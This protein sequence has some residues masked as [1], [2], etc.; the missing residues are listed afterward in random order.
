M[1]TVRR[2]WILSVLAVPLVAGACGAPVAP[3]SNLP[4]VSGNYSQPP[5]PAHAEELTAAPS[6]TP[7]TAS[8]G[9]PLA[10]LRPFPDP[11]SPPPSAALDAIRSHGRL[12]V[13]LD[14]GSNLF[15]FRD[16]VT[17]QIEGFDVDISREI[18]AD[19]LGS[20]DR[21]V[22]RIIGSK[23]RELALER[24]TVDI[25]AST[26]TITCE[27]RQQVAFS[28]VYFQANQRILALRDSGINDLAD[29]AGKRVCVAT[30]T[31][32]LEH[33]QQYQPA[34]SILTVPT[35]A[36]C[37]VV[38]QQ[39]QVDAV[40]TDDSILAGM[41]AQ[42]PYVQIVG[43]SISPEAYGIGINKDDPDLVRFVNGTLQRIR[44]DGTWNRIYNRWLSVLGPSPGPPAPQ[45][46]D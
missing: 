24:H 8:C 4:S 28:T 44:A 37:L 41:V 30:G 42:D 23:Y 43:P 13:G 9:N 12:I 33:I 39:R 3:L 29:L 35:W 22:F 27:R 1:R 34:A 25:V 31:T 21:V 15:S 20:P 36:D 32:S 17:G 19:L 46:E 2:R 10:S 7:A 14:T 26:M 38:L 5:M 6:P 16:P 45:Y 11:A 40:S 18:A